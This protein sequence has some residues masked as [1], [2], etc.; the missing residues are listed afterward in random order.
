[1]P[2]LT[3]TFFVR[4]RCDRPGADP[5][6]Q[7]QDQGAEK[8]GRAARASGRRSIRL[9]RVSR[10]VGL[11]NNRAAQGKNRPRTELYTQSKRSRRSARL[12]GRS[13]F[14]AAK[15]RA[16]TPL[17]RLPRVTTP[18]GA[19]DRRTFGRMPKVYVQLINL[20]RRTFRRPLHSVCSPFDALLLPFRGRIACWQ[21]ATM[22]RGRKLLTPAELTGPAYV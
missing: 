5:W 17:R 1:M 15:A 14:G 21:R 19:F 7:G 4:T 13:R 10:S 12:R 9:F 6:Y 2:G 22:P 20:G 18:D 16:P 8:R 3:V 11:S